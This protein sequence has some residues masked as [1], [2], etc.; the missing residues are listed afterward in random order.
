[1]VSDTGTLV[2]RGAEES[3]ERRGRSVLWWNILVIV[4]VLV[5]SAFETMLVPALPMI[6]DDLG[7]TVS[8]SAWALT[9]FMLTAAVSLPIVGKLGDIFGARRV[10]VVVLVAL[11]AGVLLPPAG[12]SFAALVVGQGLQGLGMSLIPLGVALLSG[13]RG[14][15]GEIRSAALM[16]A[17]AVSTALGMVLAGVLLGFADWR[18]LYWGAFIFDCA[19][20]SCALFLLRR[21]GTPPAGRAQGAIDWLG[22]LLLGGALLA[23]LLAITLMEGVGWRSPWVIAL[24]AASLVLGVS[25]VLH[26]LRAVQP[27]IDLGLLRL[28][29][30]NRVVIVQFF[31]GFGTFA[32]FISVPL[33]MQSP[34]AQGGLG[35][36]A[37]ASGYALAPFGISA[38]L[39]PVLVSRLRALFGAAMVM[40]VGSL[41]A[42]AAP[43]LLLVAS[44]VMM[45]GVA[46]G[47]LGLGIGLIITQSFDLVGSTVP[48][49]RVASMSSLIYVLKM[50]GASLGGQASTSLIGTVPSSENFS[51]ALLLALA[52]MA[53]SALAALT[54]LK[55]LHGEDLGPSYR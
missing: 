12:N 55:K 27:L 41:I 49:D 37:S 42:V 29:A 13:Q 17:G 50:V 34:P 8:Q 19:I 4:A 22:A 1:M 10:L 2:E 46:M 33:I 52:V 45:V 25:G 5:N 48:Q 14:E 7:L 28:R 32:T 39:A 53:A 24:A 26:S 54:L 35:L 9:V 30:I 21:D 6:L 20:V 16:T 18:A 31:S 47:A 38:I 43:A 44:D 23:L 15:G 51:H 3:G 40:S 36:D 11:T